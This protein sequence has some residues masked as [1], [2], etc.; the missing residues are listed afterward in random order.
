MEKTT[1]YIGFRERYC[2][3]VRIGFDWFDYRDD[4]PNLPNVGAFCKKCA[5]ETAKPMMPIYMNGKPAYGLHCDKCGSEYTMYKSMF[6]ERYVGYDL[7]CGGHVNP[8]HG[9]KSRVASMDRKAKD[10]YNDREKRVESS[11]CEMMNCSTEEYRELK[12]KWAE[13]NK[14]LG[15]KFEREQAERRAGWENEKRQEESNNRKELIDKGIIKYVKN[16]GLVNTKT[17]EI[18]KL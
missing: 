9:T 4:E 13:E 18:V 11:M 12:K 17:G 5:K 6:I 16:V 3:I 7:A 8:T 14:K 1:E 2:N 10:Y 15:R